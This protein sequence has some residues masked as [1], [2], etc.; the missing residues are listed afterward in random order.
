MVSML[1][2]ALA[3]LICASLTAC[4]ATSALESQSKPASA[5]NARIYILRPGALSGG[6]MAANVRIN[7]AEVGYVAN[8]S[9]L[10]VDR[11]PGRHKIEVRLTAGLAGH[12]HEARVEAGRTYYFAYNAG[13]AVT[14]LGAIPIVIPGPTEGRQVS[15]TSVA[16]ALLTGGAYLAELDAAAGAETVARMKGQA[17]RQRGW[18]VATEPAAL[19]IR[20]PGRRG[21][22]RRLTRRPAS[23]GSATCAEPR[24][25]APWRV[26]RRG[27]AS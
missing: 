7:G 9:Y 11:P 20:F 24:R 2:V 15:Q 5:Q 17:E 18:G 26:S 14:T 21:R 6:A 22:S 25:R 13:A 1:R 4:A 10:F 19:I 3:A 12:E 23:C 8:G 16:S 27:S